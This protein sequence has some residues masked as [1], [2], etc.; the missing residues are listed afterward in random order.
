MANLLNGRVSKLEA[1][2]GPSGYSGATRVI[3]HGPVD[4]EAVRQAESAADKGG[5]LL[6]VRRIVS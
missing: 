2:Q 6:I 5:K 3:W 4:D 1:V